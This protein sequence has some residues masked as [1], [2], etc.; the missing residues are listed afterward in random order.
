MLHFILISEKESDL[1][2]LIYV[3]KEFVIELKILLV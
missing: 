2:I 1:C 3:L